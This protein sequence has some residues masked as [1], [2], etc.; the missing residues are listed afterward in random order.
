MKDVDPIGYS[1][2][3]S[4]YTDL[5]EIYMRK[6]IKREM[7]YKDKDDRGTLFVSTV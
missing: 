2:V 4:V 6:T 3:G 7:E 1:Q 5:Y